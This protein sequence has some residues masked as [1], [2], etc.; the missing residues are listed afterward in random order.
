MDVFDFLGFLKKLNMYYRIKPF[1]PRWLQIFLRRLIIHQK[2]ALYHKIW[3][4]NEKAAKLP[5]GWGGWPHNKKF[6][7]I[8]THDV[9]YSKGQEKCIKLAELEK[10]L[11]FRS[12]FNFVPKRYYVSP[13]IRKYLG[14]NGFEVG[15]HGLYHDG[16]LYSSRRIYQKRAVE[17]NKYLKEWGAVGFRAPSMHHNLDWNCM[18]NI[19]YDA[20]TFDTDP[21]EPQ[22]DGIETIFPVKIENCPI[23]TSDYKYNGYIELPYTLSQDF[24]L[25]IILREKNID[26]WKKKLDWIVEKG[27]M[28]L[29]NTH[30]DYMNFEG[31]P[32]KMDEYPYDYYKAFLETIKTDYKDKYWHVLP[33]EMAR[34]WSRDWQTDSQTV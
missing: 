12:A 9:E 19:E 26:T 13:E 31:G 10:E 11:G 24:A 3:P 15:V 18:L 20:S 34:Y 22:S 16:R 7:L 25:F 14:E 2:K 8:L 30:P 4:I 32:C 21:F 23:R 29:L 33:K 6:A 5:Y 28:A 1:I 27:G 17:I